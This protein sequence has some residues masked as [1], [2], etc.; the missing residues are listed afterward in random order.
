MIDVKDPMIDVGDAT[1]GQV[2]LGAVRKQ[3]EQATKSK[4]VSSTPAGLC[5]RP[6]LQVPALSLADFIQ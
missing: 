5:S 3:D 1:C 4:S 2:V 6:C